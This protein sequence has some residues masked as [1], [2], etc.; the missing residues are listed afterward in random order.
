MWNVKTFRKLLQYP[1][2]PNPIFFFLLFCLSQ[3]D[4]EQLRSS[5]MI[6]K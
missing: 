1:P 3:S 2:Q 5:E 4:D 6:A